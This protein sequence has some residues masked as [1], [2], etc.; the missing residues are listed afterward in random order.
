MLS[1]EEMR[2]ARLRAMGVIVPEPGSSNDSRTAPR[3]TLTESSS[4]QLEKKRYISA[5]DSKPLSQDAMK[6]IKKLMYEDGGATDEDMLRW[7][8]QG[9]NF[10]E[11]PSFGLRQGNGGPCGILAAVQAEI[12][13]CALFS[14]SLDN[15][16][17]TSLPSPSSSEV[18]KM[19]A[20]ACS[21]ILSRAAEGRS[22][23]A[24]VCVIDCPSLSLSPTS[25][26]SQLVVHRLQS[27][28]EVTRFILDRLELF[29]SNIGCITFLISLMLSRGLER[30]AQDM[31][32]A[33]NTLIGPYGH[34]AQELLNLLLTGAA[35]SNIM[36]GNISMNGTVTFIGWATPMAY[37]T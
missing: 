35:N 31:D 21:A 20:S 28:S 18:Q 37:A 29:S 5:D 34:C 11:T 13:K 3:E 25:P 9:F 16:G 12:L 14:N 32:I 2:N 1:K 10:C 6:A 4:E 26:S 36:D 7:Y 17:V 23:S 27:G 24:E 8:N 33:S 15:I 30:V 22:N 19:F